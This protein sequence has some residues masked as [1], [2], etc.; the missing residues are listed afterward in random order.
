M[1][2]DASRSVKNLPLKIACIDNVIID[3]AEPAYTGGSQIIGAG[4]AQ[5]S[6]PDNQDAGFAQ[7][8]LAFTADLFEDNMTA[9]SLDFFFVKVCHVGIFL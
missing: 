2:S 6:S 1:H 3:N 9:I 5:P 8:L 4:R 7:L